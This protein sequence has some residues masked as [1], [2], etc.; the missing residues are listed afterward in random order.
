MYLIFLTVYNLDRNIVSRCREPHQYHGS[1]M[2]SN[3]LGRHAY[4]TVAGRQ[5]ESQEKL[6]F[7]DYGEASSYG[8]N[9]LQRIA[10]YTVRNTTTKVAV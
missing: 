7:M 9:Q 8:T 10:I 6:I 5:L 1:N 3:V 2:P 4:F